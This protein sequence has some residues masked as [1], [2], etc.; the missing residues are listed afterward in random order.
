LTAEYLAE[1][2]RV[3]L[4]WVD[5]STGEENFEIFRNDVR[6]G[7]VGRGIVAASDKNI[8]VGETY[9]YKVRAKAG[10]SLS[11][12]SNVVTVKTAVDEPDPEPTP[13]GKLT[14]TITGENL[15]FDVKEG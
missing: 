4:R 11:V 7:Q 12:F 5:N 8:E 13:T 10:T 2:G 3:V 15:K 1:E 9:T 6:L 14:F